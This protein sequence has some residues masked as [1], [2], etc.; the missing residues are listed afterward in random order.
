MSLERRIR[1]LRAKAAS[2]A[3]PEEAD[4]A[5]QLADKLEAKLQAEGKREPT[6]AERERLRKLHGLDD[7]PPP[8]RW[9]WP[10]PKEPD[11]SGTKTAKKPWRGSAGD[12]DELYR[13]L[14]E[15]AQA[16]MDAERPSL[17]LRVREILARKAA[18]QEMMSRF[19]LD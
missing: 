3:F 17:S 6:D 14:L 12:H 11:R 13:E 8:P 9:E 15:Q 2:T 10:A 5:R 7:R 19:G 16:K 1:A 4:T 18:M